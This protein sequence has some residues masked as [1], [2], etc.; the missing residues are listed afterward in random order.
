MRHLSSFIYLHLCVMSVFPLSQSRVK[1]VPFSDTTTFSRYD[2]IYYSRNQCDQ[3]Q[4]LSPSSLLKKEIFTS[5]PPK[6]SF[7]QS[8][9][10]SPILHTC[11]LYCLNHSL[12]PP[13]SALSISFSASLILFWVLLQTVKICQ[14]F[15]IFI[16]FLLPVSFHPAV[17]VPLFFICITPLLFRIIKNYCT[18]FS[19]VRFHPKQHNETALEKITNNFLV[20]RKIQISHLAFLTI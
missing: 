14:V 13:H 10:M 11:S 16:E 4:I 9:L 12:P 17:C 18:Y 19:T 7:F 6:E 8:R 2:P 15:F 1:F 3:I 5:F 20:K